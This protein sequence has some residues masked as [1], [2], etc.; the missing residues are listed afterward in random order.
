M[1]PC[2]HRDTNHHHQHQFCHTNAEWDNRREKVDKN[3]SNMLCVPPL[4]KV[5]ISIPAWNFIPVCVCAFK[6]VCVSYLLLCWIIQQEEVDAVTSLIS[7]SMLFNVCH[8]LWKQGGLGS[9]QRVGWLWSGGG[10]GGWL[11]LLSFFTSFL[12]RQRERE[13]GNESEAEWARVK[14]R[15]FSIIDFL[16]LP[17]PR[18]TSQ[19]YFPPC[20]SVNSVCVCLRSSLDLHV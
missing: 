11:W 15:V 16:C 13:R 14:W 6:C 17:A 10:V 18:V 20:V 19:V 4:I 3:Y 2:Q 8:Y 9:V 12:E 5:I 7:C 1:T